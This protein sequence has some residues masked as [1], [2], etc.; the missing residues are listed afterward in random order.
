M[1]RQS[2]PVLSQIQQWRRGFSDKSIQPSWCCTISTRSAE[3]AS[4]QD[5]SRV[6]KIIMNVTKRSFRIVFYTLK[7]R[8]L[9][10]VQ[11]DLLNVLLLKTI[12]AQKK[13]LWM[14]LLVMLWMYSRTP[15]GLK[16][17]FR[18]GHGTFSTLWRN[19]LCWWHFSHALKTSI[20]RKTQMPWGFVV[21]VFFCEL[22][23]KKFSIREGSYND[24]C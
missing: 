10:L 5:I 14:Y 13:L 3:C 8:D 18:I 9:G 16:R 6:E 24:V 12:P 19:L 21:L 23:K 17:S 15:T 1:S 11:L 7:N 20:S 2:N 4:S 22:S